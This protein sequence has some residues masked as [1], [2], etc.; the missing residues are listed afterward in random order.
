VHSNIPNTLDRPSR[1]PAARQRGLRLGDIYAFLKEAAPAE[2]FTTSSVMVDNRITVEC[3]DREFFP[4][5]FTMFGG[6]APIVGR[7][8]IPSDIHLEIH[9]RA[10][11][12][13]GWFRMTGS[14][15]LP[16][17]GRELSFAIELEQGQFELLD[18]A[19]DGWKC[20][21]FRGSDV[22]TFAFRGRDCLFS[23]DPRWR[24]CII[25]YLFWRLLRIRS[26]AIF[27]HASAVNIF[28]E[29]TIFIGPAGGGKSTTSLALAA[30]GHNF[31]SDEIAGYLPERGELIPFRRPVGIKRGPRSSAVQAGLSPEAA[32]RIDRDGFLR[33]DIDTLFPVERPQPVPLRRMVFL[34][35]F[36]ER[37][38]MQRITP[39]RD[40]IVELQPLMSS[41]LNASH[42]R[43]IFELTR[44]LGSSKV[45]QLHPGE[46]DATAVYVEE[47][48]AC[49]RSQQS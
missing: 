45:Y 46:P 7:L 41:F 44:L 8:S 32:A 10:R 12:D 36:A 47:F 24:L 31:L 14:N 33:V 19:E 42:G 28:G 18:V 20:V 43:R 30:R 34:R 4:D 39:G 49:E 1:V 9:T 40:E 6:P 27:F 35:G 26:D 15:D 17:D 38:A 29:G 2:M 22:P 21:A 13:F 48:F 3:D 37:P 16:I 5:F 11:P 25:W 23:L